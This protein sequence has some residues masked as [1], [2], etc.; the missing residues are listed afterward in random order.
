[1]N[2]NVKNHNVCLNQDD[3]NVALRKAIKYNNKENIKK[4]KPWIYV[5]LALW[6]IFSLWA[7]VLAMQAPVGPQRVTHI[8]F[9]VVFGP[10]YVLSHYLSSMSSPQQYRREY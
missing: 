5:A 4:A 9:A 7:I 6:L 1:M 3:F 8:T 2:R 10:A